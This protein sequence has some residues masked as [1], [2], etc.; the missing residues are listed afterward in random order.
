MNALNTP[1]IRQYPYP[2]YRIV[3]FAKAPEAGRVKTRLQPALGE[4]GSLQLHQRLV[5][6]CFTTLREA[7]VAPVELAVAGYTPNPESQQYFRQL[8]ADSQVPI[9]RQQGNDLGERMLYTA[10]SVLAENSAENSAEG[11]V[12]SGAVIIVGSDCPFFERDYLH[13]ACQAL[14]DGNDCV[15]G[16]AHDGGYVL[17][18]LRRTDPALFDNVPWGT[19]S[20]LEITRQRLSKLGWQWCELELKTDIDRPEDLQLLS[21]LWPDLGVF[22]QT[23]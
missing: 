9:V 14:A 20:V 22:Q 2:N 4:S 17:I 18:G 7:A 10:D 16:P 1:Y 21:G 23:I 19:D 3:Q 11:G 8:V 5:G 12:E 6:H 13:S 15:L